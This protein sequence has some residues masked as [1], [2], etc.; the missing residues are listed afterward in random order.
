MTHHLYHKCLSPFLLQYTPGYMHTI[1]HTSLAQSWHCP[2]AIPEGLGYKSN[3][4]KQTVW[5]FV[6]YLRFRFHDPV[7][8]ITILQTLFWN[9][10]FPSC[11]SHVT[12]YLP[13]LAR[14]VDHLPL[15]MMTSSNGNI[16]RVTGHLCGE[17][18]GPRWRQWRGA[19]MFSLIWVWINGWVNNRQ[20]GDLRRY[21]AHYD[22]TV[23]QKVLVQSK[24]VFRVATNI[25]MV[26]W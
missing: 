11:T 13:M 8:C 24:P 23:M 16:L 1:L 20:A 15:P 3:S 17:F 12:E 2:I 14:L 25:L 4:A 5:I 10:N 22:V 18:T 26:W 6:L 7:L 21:P 9:V 19:L